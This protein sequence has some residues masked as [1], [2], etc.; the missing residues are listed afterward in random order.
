D[1]ELHSLIKLFRSSKRNE[2]VH[3]RPVGGRQ[4][5]PGQLFRRHPLQ[6]FAAQ[7]TTMSVLDR[8]SEEMQLDCLLRVRVA[9]D[10]ERRRCGDLDAQ[11]LSQFPAQ[12]F[13]QRFA[14]LS[15]SSRKLPESAQMDIGLTLRE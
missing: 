1:G 12:T 11:L 7:G 2:C 9:D 5:H 10:L 4:G 6:G 15:L 13:L 3:Q 14:R 8:A